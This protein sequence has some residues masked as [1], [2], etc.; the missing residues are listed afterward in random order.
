MMDKKNNLPT[1]RRFW[2]D[3]QPCFIHLPEKP[4]GF[5]ILYLGDATQE[6]TRD[7]T[8]WWEHPERNKMLQMLLDNGYTLL[9]SRLYGRNWGSPN[10]VHLMEQVY[11]AVIRQEI[12]NPHV[13]ILAE[14]MGSLTS[15]KF[16]KEHP[17]HIRSMTFIN[18]CLNL[19]AMYK[20]ERNNRLFYKRLKREVADAYQIEDAEEVG[21]LFEHFDLREHSTRVPVQI[22]HDPTDKNYPFEQHSRMFEKIQKEKNHKVRFVLSVKPYFPRIYNQISQFYRQYETKLSE[23]F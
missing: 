10:A 21:K 14:G 8:F 22:F 23:P 12:L 11:Q 19:K 15:L 4:N 3:E 7:S 18:P 1:L 13:H 6:V 20:H 9:T 5:L 2:I 16:A 17:N